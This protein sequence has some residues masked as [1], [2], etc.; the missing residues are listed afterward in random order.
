[1][2]RLSL[3]SILPWVHYVQTQTSPCTASEC[4]LSIGGVSHVRQLLSSP[5]KPVRI[6]Y[7]MGIPTPSHYCKH[8]QY[9][10]K[11]TGQDVQWVSVISLH[12]RVK[13]ACGQLPACFLVASALILCQISSGSKG[14]GLLENVRVLVCICSCVR[15]RVRARAR[16]HLCMHV[17]VCTCMYVGRPRPGLH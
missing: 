2:M 15:V 12:A 17:P 14:L 10:E 4:S 13:H 9:V 7:S 11:V 5:A 6:G 3:L 1:M 16:I 8:H